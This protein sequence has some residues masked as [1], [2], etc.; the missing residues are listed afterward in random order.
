M[1][2]F[3]GAGVVVAGLAGWGV[4]HNGL[5]PVRSLTRAAER[6]ARTEELQPIEV[7]GHDEI[8]RLASAFNAML[9]ALA[10]SRDRQRQLVADASHELR[11]PLTSLRTNLD[12]LTQADKQ[13]GLS[14]SSRRE[15][16]A[17]VRFQI[18]E[19]TTLVG[20][21]VAL[22]RDE[23]LER[24]VEP[25]DLAEVTT[26]AVERVRRRAPNLHFAV[27]TSSWWVTGEDDDLER[28][29]TNLLDNA[30]KWSPPL[31]VVT[32]ALHDGTLLVADQGPGIADED[33]PH[34]FDRFYR[35]TES[36]TMPGS[37]LGLAI[38]RQVA[39]R[40]G[41]TVRAGRSADEGAAFWFTVPGASVPPGPEAAVDVV[42][43]V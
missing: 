7:E 14:E 31:G 11:T 36:R 39:E 15:L 24:A 32:V 38:V 30:A 20:D 25:V 21:L 8:A 2:L 5:R 27:D 23:P 19:L 13:G 22:A 16:M 40:H 29:V 12:L 34:V 6:I 41:G 33:L 18:E 17:D 42:E 4:A 3:G 26:R 9:A 43:R 10:A 1:L 35:S 28:A 37:G